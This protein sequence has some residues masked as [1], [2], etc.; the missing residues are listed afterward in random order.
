MMK[1]NFAVKASLFTLILALL[2][3]GTF[4]AVAVMK[5]NETPVVAKAS[6]TFYYNGPS[7]NLATNVMNP[8]N[9]S[10]SQDS[11]FTCGQPTEIP[12]SLDV[13]SDKTIE[14]HLE[15]LDNL[16]AVQEASPSKRS[17]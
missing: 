14:D 6:T 12:C 16:A 1:N 11:G 5:K 7:T 9:W 13:P 10:P 3:I 2:A 8:N 4:A 17:E 15:D